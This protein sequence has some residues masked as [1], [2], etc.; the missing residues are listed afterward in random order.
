MA[1][2][3]CAVCMRDVESLDYFNG[4]MM[5]EECYNEPENYVF[6]DQKEVNK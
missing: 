1:K 5:C 3:E 6:G 2:T 4:E